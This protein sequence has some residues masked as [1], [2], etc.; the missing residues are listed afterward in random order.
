[1]TQAA[2]ALG[3]GGSGSRLISCRGGCEEQERGSRKAG[4][5]RVCPEPFAL[6]G[7]LGCG[8]SHRRRALGALGPLRERGVERASR[9][10]PGCSDLSGLTALR[11]EGGWSPARRIPRRA[12]AS[13]GWK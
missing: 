1:V 13:A 10:W 7:G 5:P 4:V 11:G 6:P 8:V 3:F 9:P 12:A 2:S